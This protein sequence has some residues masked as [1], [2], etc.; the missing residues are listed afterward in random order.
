MRQD[1]NPFSPQHAPKHD[2]WSLCFD[3]DLANSNR[4][5]EINTNRPFYKVVVSSELQLATGPSHDITSPLTGLEEIVTASSSVPSEGGEDNGDL[6]NESAEQLEDEDAMAQI[7]RYGRSPSSARVGKKENQ[8]VG[9]A[10]GR[11]VFRFQVFSNSHLSG[12]PLDTSAEE[13]R[14]YGSGAPFWA[15]ALHKPPFRR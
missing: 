12:R 7:L 3:A 5:F 8:N 2:P 9:L 14:A 6:E 13:R 11:S 4:P 1:L 10:K 15:H